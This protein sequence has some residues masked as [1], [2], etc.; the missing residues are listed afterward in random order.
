MYIIHQTEK[1]VVIATK[2]S[3]NRKTGES[4]QIWILD[5]R[6]HP[7]ESRRTGEDAQN[8]CQGCAFASGNGCYVNANP[9]SSIWRAWKR[10]SYS[11]LI[12]GSPEWNQFFSTEFVRFGAYGNPSLLPLPMVKDIASRARKITG[13]FHDWHMMPKETAQ[14]YGEFFMASCEVGNYQKAQSLGLRTFSVVPSAFPAAGIECLA[15]AKGL[16]CRQCGLCD[17]NRRTTTRGKALPNVFITVHGYQK[18]KA[19]AASLGS[20]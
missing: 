4:V 8:Q 15:D 19:I 20:N 1:V 17:G 13:Y 14:A 16:T 18:Q 9:L 12:M 5:S 7:V 3:T 6:M 10:G 11:P 2:N